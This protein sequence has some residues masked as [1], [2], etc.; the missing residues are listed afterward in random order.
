MTNASKME[1]CFSHNS[2]REKRPGPGKRRQRTM[3]WLVTTTTALLT[4]VGVVGA[5]S[6]TVFPR[7]CDGPQHVR[8]AVGPDPA[9]EMIVSFGSIPSFVAP[10]VGGVL[11]G[12][13]PLAMHTLHME[14]ATGASHYNIP[15]EQKYSNSQESVYYS[16]YYHHV[17]ISGLLPNTTYYYEPM[18]HRNTADFP[19]KDV[20]TVWP[21]DAAEAAAKF[22]ETTSNEPDEDYT[23][24][25]RRL[26]DLDAYDGRQTECPSETKIRS[27]RTAPAPNKD[28]KGSFV[29]MGDLGQYPHSKEALSRMIRM[30]DSIDTVILAG[31][32]AYARNDDR[33]WDTFLDFLDDYPIAETKPMQIVPGNHDINKLT[34]RQEIFLGY[35]HRFRMPRVKPAELGIYDGPKGPLNMGKEQLLTGMA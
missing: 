34:D 20:V 32:L 14:P 17:T 15:V 30:R 18:F 19:H 21:D 23:R 12:T 28:A 10:P 9:T 1:E 7:Y 13:S 8:I 11:V 27:F 16:L 24:R 22:A 29:I 25:K 35:E 2:C 31:D 33:E 3:R 4:H 26:G 6:S 5:S